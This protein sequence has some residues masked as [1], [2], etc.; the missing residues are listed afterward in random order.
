VHVPLTL[1]H[2]RPLLTR[3]EVFAAVKVQVEFFCVV[4]S[5]S[6]V[7]EYKRFGGLS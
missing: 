7:V 3:F 2:R 1:E 4:T 6:I 5:Q